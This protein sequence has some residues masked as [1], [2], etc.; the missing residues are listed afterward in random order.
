MRNAVLLIAASILI[1][2]PSFGADS[3]RWHGSNGEIVIWHNGMKTRT[4]NSGTNDIDGLHKFNCK[5]PT[6][7]IVIVSASI[8]EQRSSINTTCAY[9]DG[10]GGAPG[11]NEDPQGGSQIISSLHEQFRVTSGPRTVQT[12]VQNSGTTAMLGWAIDYTIYDQPN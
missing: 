9:V 1:A 8:R 7:C 12:V 5:N 3:K 10:I 11:C 4:L 2:S 6:G